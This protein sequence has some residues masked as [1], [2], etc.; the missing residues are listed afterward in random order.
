MYHYV[1]YE[2]SESVFEETYPTLATFT[3]VVDISTV[4]PK[5]QAMLYEAVQYLQVRVS[6]TF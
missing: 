4:G 1:H 6:V 5:V 3:P 2:T